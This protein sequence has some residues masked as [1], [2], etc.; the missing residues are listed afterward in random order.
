[1][2][3]L[4]FPLEGVKVVEMGTHVSIPTVSRIMADWGAE[5][6][7]IENT[8]GEEWRV[9]GKAYKLPTIDEENTLFTLQNS[10]KQ[11]ISI[12]AKSPEGHE[13]LMKLI[14]DA[15]VFMSNVRAKSLAK[16]G[17]DYE[18]LKALYPSLIYVHLSGYGY[19]GPD[20]SLP[21]FD[22]A[23][24][25][26]RT[27][28]MADWGNPGDFPIKPPG[29]FGDAT[30]SSLLLSGVLAALFAR[31]RSGRGTMISSSLYGTGIW[32]NQTGITCT[33]E[34]YG[35]VYPKSRYCPMNPFSHLYECRDHEWLVLTVV[36]YNQG[37]ARVMEVLGLEQYVDDPKYNTIEAVQKCTEEFIHMINDAF[38]KRDRAEWVKL[39]R[40]ADLVCCELRHM[41]E[42]TKDPQALENGFFEKVRFANGHEALMPNVNVSFSSYNTRPYSP[43]G[44][45]G[46]DTAAVLKKYGYTDEQ[47]R[48]MLAKGAI[49]T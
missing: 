21:G 1:M 18:T 28:I 41:C 40:Q 34:A 47:I 42:A 43:P 27:G 46:R 44:A 12:D 10:N 22:M 8:R 38:M 15:D 7:K 26:A 39:F 4:K 33:Q 13:I 24:F 35:N 17:C 14:G 20:A 36:N 16:L 6:I 11:F 30:V 48:D 29:G 49:R 9:N 5:V 19:D 31:E 25:F 3:D 45:V 32:Y 23:A 37:Y 2:K